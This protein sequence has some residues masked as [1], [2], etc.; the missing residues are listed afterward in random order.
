M[1]MDLAK[2]EVEYLAGALE[3][4]VVTYHTAARDLGVHVA[5]AK[6]LLAEY[7]AANRNT[8]SAQYI[9]TGT[10]L[11]SPVVQLVEE[12]DLAAQTELFDVHTV[13]VYCLLLAKHLFSTTDMALEELRHPVERA[14]MA[15]Y[16]AQGLIEG[17]DLS[18]V[19]AEPVKKLQLPKK[20]QLPKR[21][22]KPDVRAEP[23][24]KKQATEQKPKLEYKLR[25][26]KAKTPSLLSNYVSRKTEKSAS[27]APKPEKADK[28]DYQYKSRK[29]EKLQPKERVVMS[30]VGDDEEPEEAAAEKRPTETDLNALFMDDF[31]DEDDNAAAA[32]EEQPVVVEHAEEPEEAAPKTANTVPQDSIFRSMSLNSTSASHSNSPAPER[33]P[34][35]PAET[36]VDEDGYFTTYKPKA[37]APKSAPAKDAPK[38]APKRAAPAAKAGKTKAD[39]KKKQASL[40]SFFGKRPSD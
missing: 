4:H 22:A 18:A 8:L 40:M 7:Y 2:E 38:E 3:T 21:A 39:G 20:V 15:Q 10:R 23:A 17:P 25:K 6:R 1:T 11:G 33:E 5:A 36:T 28:P 29:Q 37:E 31:T 9:A 30:T 35:P 24:A 26:E 32:E 12:A 34:S 27:P 13:H 14:K 16:Y 19:A